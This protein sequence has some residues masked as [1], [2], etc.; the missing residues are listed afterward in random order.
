M[1]GPIGMPRRRQPMKHKKVNMWRTFDT[2]PNKNCGGRVSFAFLSPVRCRATRG[3]CVSV[4]ALV[5][6]RAPHCDSDEG[7]GMARWQ[8]REHAHTRA[9]RCVG[10]VWALPVRWPPRHMIGMLH[11]PLPI[12]QQCCTTGVHEIG[13]LQ[14]TQLQPAFHPPAISSFHSGG[15]GEHWRSNPAA[16]R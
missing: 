11:E 5:N 15:N 9:V 2:K 10:L 12:G 8:G 7:V 3:W 6:T 13:S 14:C 1:Q 4:V 16:D